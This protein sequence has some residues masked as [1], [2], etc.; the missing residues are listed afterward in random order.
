[1][2]EE[3]SAVS[4]KHCARAPS[5]SPKELLQVRKATQRLSVRQTDQ[6]PVHSCVVQVVQSEEAE[7]LPPSYRPASPALSFAASE[8][9]GAPAESMAPEANASALAVPE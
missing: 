3:A 9:P 1:V 7:P 6:A 4:Q 2:G 8:H 5:D